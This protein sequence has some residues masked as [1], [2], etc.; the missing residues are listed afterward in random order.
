VW[1][2]AE[3]PALKHVTAIIGGSFVAFVVYF[4]IWFFARN[5]VDGQGSGAEVGG[6]LVVVFI[7]LAAGLSSYRASV[8]RHER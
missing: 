8:A 6:H 5:M 4:V 3:D 7:A 1:H 2:L